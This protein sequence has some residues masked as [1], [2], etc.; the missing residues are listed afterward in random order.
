[1]DAEKKAKAVFIAVF[2]IVCSGLS[3]FFTMIGA[4]AKEMG[5]VPVLEMPESAWAAWGIM[6][7]AICGFFGG[8]LLVNSLQNRRSIVVGIACCI[9]TAVVI[10]A[11]NGFLTNTIIF[12]IIEGL[13]LGA[14]GGL[15]FS[16]AFLGIFRK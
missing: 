16:A 2:T 15:V 6:W 9:V 10:G 1:M 11:V 5:M 8:R 12:G 7:G 14:I 13:V 4:S 3:W